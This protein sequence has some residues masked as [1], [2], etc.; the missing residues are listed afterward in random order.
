MLK[1]SFTS[2]PIEVI[3]YTS[4]KDGSAQTMRKQY[5]YLHVV[6]ED[7]TPSPYPDK[8]GVLLERD[9]APYPPGEYVLHPSSVTVDREGRLSCRP[10]LIPVKAPAARG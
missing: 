4:K 8:F 3:P 9:Q 1:V 6:L 2:A 5:G 7:G 10:R